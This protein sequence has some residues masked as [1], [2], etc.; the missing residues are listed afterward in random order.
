[1][2]SLF[3][4]LLE[5]GVE[6]YAYSRSILHAKTA[7]FDDRLA[8]IGSHNLDALSCRFIS[9]VQRRRRRPTF[10]TLMRESFD[11]DCAEARPVLL[12]EWRRHA[13]WTRLVAWFAA[14]LRPL[15]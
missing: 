2:G 12:S 3:G 6:I 4:R 14:L 10:A 1:M 9:G 13:P 11:D 5:D 8:V 15:L 7:V